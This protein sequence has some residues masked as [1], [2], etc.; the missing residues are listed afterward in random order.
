MGLPSPNL[1]K[2]GQTNQIWHLL[3]Q[4]DFVLRNRNCSIQSA[5]KYT[6]HD[7]D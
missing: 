6:I 2:K 4:F 1:L 3:N 5:S 7:F